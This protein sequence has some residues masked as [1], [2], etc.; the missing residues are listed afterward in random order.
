MLPHQEDLMTQLGYT[1]ANSDTHNP[2]FVKQISIVLD[3]EMQANPSEQEFKKVLRNKLIKV[4]DDL[5]QE[6]ENL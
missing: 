3:A 1:R 2:A 6:I 4:R 5:S